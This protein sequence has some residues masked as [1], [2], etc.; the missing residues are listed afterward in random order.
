MRKVWSILVVCMLAL[1]VSACGKTE[2]SDEKEAVSSEQEKQ[3]IRVATD[4]ESVPFTFLNTETGE[5]DGLLLD[6][7]NELGNRLDVEIE[8]QNMEWTAL[9]PSVQSKKVDAVVAAMYIT[10]ERKK[11]LNFTDP[12][13]GYGEGLIVQEGDNKTKS[14]EDL[15]GKTVGVQMGT[16]YKDMLDEKAPNLDLTVKAYKTAADM[17]SDLENKRIDAMLSDKPVF[18]YLKQADP[19]MKINI[20]DEYEP[21]LFG[22]IGIGVN[23]ENEELLSRLNEKIDEIKEDG[24]LK[25]I[26]NKWQL[27]YDY[28]KNKE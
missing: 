2:V 23:K 28:E 6:I 12:I 18:E 27:D 8:L 1:V 5:L 11:V 3:V 16:S 26:Y 9:I 15:K 10:E 20:I 21:A 14:L 19:E 17:I 13:F 7:A 4:S 22:D 25:E 24:T